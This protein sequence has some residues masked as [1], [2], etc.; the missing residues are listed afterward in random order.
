MHLREGKE[1]HCSRICA[2]STGPLCVSPGS[3]TVRVGHRSD[4]APTTFPSPSG[5]HT[6]KH[7]A[8]LSLPSPPGCPISQGPARGTARCLLAPLPV[9]SAGETEDTT[10]GSTVLTAR[11]HLIRYIMGSGAR[12]PCARQEFSH[13]FVKL[14]WNLEKITC[15]FWCFKQLLCERDIVW[16]S[17]I[18]F[19][20]K[21]PKISLLQ[22]LLLLPAI[23]HSSALYELL[24]S[25]LPDC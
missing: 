17:I 18:H 1:H 16:Q 2:R 22:A 20:L 3:V 6:G 23:T 15:L 12:R 21:C 10:P 7:P 8:C 11:N 13:M 9:C 4:R 25:L 19:L 24:Q 14:H 5:P